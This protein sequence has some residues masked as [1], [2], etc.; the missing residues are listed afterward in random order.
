M[1]GESR[2]KLIIFLG[3]AAGVGKTYTMLSEAKQKLKSGADVKV[4]FIETHG[5]EDTLEMIGEIPVIPRRKTVYRGVDLEEMDLEAV[6]DAHPSI[7]LVDEMAHTNVPGSKHRK[8][9]ED[10]E[11][12]LKNGID[13]WTTVNIQHMES[14]NDLVYESTGVK[15]RETFPDSLL[16]KAEQVRLIDIDPQAL[17]ER[18]KAGKVYPPGKI[19]QALDNFFRKS[20]LVVLRELALRKVA[21]E[22]EETIEEEEAPSGSLERIMVCVRPE[23]NAQRIIRRGWRTSRRLGASLTVIYARA[24][25]DQPS[26][27]GSSHNTGEE[28][29]RINALRDLAAVL[30]AEFMEVSGPDIVSTIIEAARERRITQILIG[31]PHRPR[32]LLRTRSS[33]VYRILFELSEVDLHIIS[34]DPSRIQE[35]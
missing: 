28:E 35:D 33:I 23:G 20:N 16:E 22:V 1:A 7:A 32:F 25:S 6:L 18:I 24:E 31:R 26:Q 9:Y 13:V 34:E 19:E 17:I 2:G 21:D 8:R 14:L 30:G 15:V 4:A 3:S 10:I 11:E 5:R 12:L 27:P 29:E